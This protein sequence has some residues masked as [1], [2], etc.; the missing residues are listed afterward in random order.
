MANAPTAVYWIGANGNTYVKAAGSNGVQD[1]GKLPTGSNIAGATQINDPSAPASG[2]AASGSGNGADLSSYNQG[3]DATNAQINALDPQLNTVLGTVGNN[4]QTTLNNLN[5]DK[6]T[7]EDTYTKNKT[8]DAQDFVGAKNT[9]GTNTGATINTIGSVLGARGAGGQSAGDYAT[10]VAAGQG[11]QQRAAA[12][13]NFGKNEQSLD[14]SINTYRTGYDTNVKNA[15]LQ[16]ENDENAAR[17]STATAKANLL[18]QLATLI[19]QR[20]SASGGS[21]TA[22]SQPY[23]DQAKG[24]LATA[25]T[26]ATPTPV[27]P[28]T[29]TVYQAPTLASYTTSPTAVAPSATGGAA[30]EAALPFLSTLLGRNKQLAL[31]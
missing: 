21:G 11:G 23:I 6:A 25:G 9:I 30:Q 2:P 12:G 8:A 17:A 14:T 24:L 22:G 15:T 16:K 7:T 5:Q 28:V 29:P 3:I 20:T 27:A 18:Q 26:L 19:N 10:L 4:F 1:Y 13:T 31:A